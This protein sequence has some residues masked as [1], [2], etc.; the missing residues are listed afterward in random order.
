MRFPI[1]SARALLILSFCAVT[2]SY[3]RAETL[4]Y[5]HSGK[6]DYIGQGGI[7]NYTDANA[8]ILQYRRWHDQGRAVAHLFEDDFHGRS[9]SSIQLSNIV[10][11]IVL[12]GLGSLI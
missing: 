11:Q 3:A 7:F 5:L 2:A 1:V 9:F 4:V 12:G 10:V 6:G 8:Q